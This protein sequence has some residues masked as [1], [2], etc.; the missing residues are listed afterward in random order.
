MSSC[1]C[2]TREQQSPIMPGKAALCLT[3]EH[4]ILLYTPAG[5]CACALACLCALACAWRMPCVPSWR[6]S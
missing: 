1:G 6:I 5:L 3:K 2:S 4:T